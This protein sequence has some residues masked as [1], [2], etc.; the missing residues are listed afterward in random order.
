MG[1]QLSPRTQ[2]DLSSL[3]SVS[4]LSGS[5]PR[6][7]LHICSPFIKRA[8]LI[9]GYVSIFFLLLALHLLAYLATYCIFYKL[10]V[11]VYSSLLV[12][13]ENPLPPQLKKK[14]SVNCEI[15]P[16]LLQVLI[17]MSFRLWLMGGSMPLFSEQDNP[18]SFSPHLLTRS[19][20]M[21]AH[22]HRH[23]HTHTHSHIYSYW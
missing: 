19:A 1:P 16:S 12:L 20:N 8:F 9:S 7:L 17:I 6:D 22:R 21:H 10:Y 5:R 18:A 23:T 11:C 4:H 3:F 2:C 13:Y 14:T 15:F